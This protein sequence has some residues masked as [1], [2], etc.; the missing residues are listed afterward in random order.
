[1]CY[2]M[3]CRYERKYGPDAGD[4]TLNFRQTWMPTDAA[5]WIA[6]HPE[7]ES[8]NEEEDEDE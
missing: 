6:D 1:M 7:H 8:H 3:G 4:C 2:G 5:C